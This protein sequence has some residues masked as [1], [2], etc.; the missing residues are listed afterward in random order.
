MT[1]TPEERRQLVAIRLDNA[2]GTLADAETLTAHGRLRSALNRAYYAMFYAVSALAIS[3]G[4][5][6]RKHT[7]LIAFFQREYVR[8]GTIERRHGRALQKAFEDR[9]EADYQDF[10]RF[11]GEDVERRI[12]E[13]REFVTAVAGLLS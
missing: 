3:R 5:S 4:E 6:H 9:S 7:Q 13:A 10:L 1:M 12:G 2:R 11:T 8:P